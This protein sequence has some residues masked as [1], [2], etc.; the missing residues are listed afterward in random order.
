MD[1]SSGPGGSTIDSGLVWAPVTHPFT[2]LLTLHSPPS[3]SAL[4]LPPLLVML[5]PLTAQSLPIPFKK[6]LQLPKP[7]LIAP[8]PELRLPLPQQAPE[9]SLSTACVLLHL[10]D[11]GSTQVS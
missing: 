9:L 2:T 3:R 1:E 10:W 11:L 7:A 6:S 8:F 4:R 5:L